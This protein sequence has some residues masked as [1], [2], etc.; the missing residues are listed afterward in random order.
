MGVELPVPDPTQ[1]SRRSAALPVS[2]P[3]CGATNPRHIV[4]DS[5]GVKIYGEGE[6]KVREHGVGKRRTWRKVHLAIDADSKEVVGVAVTTVEWADGEVFEE[7]L[8][9]VDGAVSQVDADGAYDTHAVHDVVAARGAKAV[10]PPR[11]NAVPWE[12]NQPRT[13]ILADIALLGR[14]GWKKPSGYH[15][16]SLAENAMYR[17]KQLFSDR[18]ASR[19][20]ETPVTEVHARIAAMNIITAL[21]MPVSVRLGVTAP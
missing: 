12:E 11:K 20:F 15:R 8:G 2:I 5:T 6:W 21:G 14:P 10:I 16:R 1:M 3:R 7:L 18:L 9:Q 19:Q 4:V 13:R 17:L